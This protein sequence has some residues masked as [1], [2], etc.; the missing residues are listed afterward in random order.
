MRPGDTVI[1]DR[2]RWT[3]LERVFEGNGQSPMWWVIEPE[4]PRERLRLLVES[5]LVVVDS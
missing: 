2:K 3:L 5:D 4:E 1:W